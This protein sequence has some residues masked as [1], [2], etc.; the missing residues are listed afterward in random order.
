MLNLCF[1]QIN[2]QNFNIM[3]TKFQ[4]PPTEPKIQ[5]IGVK[6]T[7]SEISKVKTFCKENKVSQSNL[8]R[9]AIRHFIPSL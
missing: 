6:L 8:I 9:H 5:I 2:K 3:K 1:S 7:I 4:I